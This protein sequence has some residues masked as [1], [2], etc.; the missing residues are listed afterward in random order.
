M[1]ELLPLK[2]GYYIWHYVPSLPAAIIFLALYLVVTLAQSWRLWRTRLWFC[3]PF[4][5]GGFME[6]IGYVFR[7]ICNNETNRLL[8]Y[9][10]QSIFILL[11]PILFAASIYMVLGRIIRATGG[12]QYSVI[13]PAILTKTFV[14]ADVVA[15]CVQ[16]GGAG[17]QVVS[18]L[19]SMGEWIVVAGLVIQIAMF[20]FFVVTAVIF[21]RRFQHGSP[22]AATDSTAGWK[23]SLY[24]LY[25]VS[26]LIMVRSIF[27][28]VEFVTGYSGYVMA[29]EWTIYV[30]D[31]VP[32][33]FVM[34]IF[35][36]YWPRNLGPTPDD[37][38]CAFDAGFSATDNS[39]V[40]TSSNIEL[41]E[42]H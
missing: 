29:N 17:L 23:S 2:S 26:A 11:P 36:F 28:V 25:G 5:V 35:F 39:F 38:A 12:E 13:R 21:Q 37:Q 18:S 3:I 20:G 27:R 19:S 16:G 15:F 33:F 30:F 31:A 22:Q 9:I 40:K 41:N 32:M 7:A 4:V 14:W 6:V 42:R 8:P 24:M 10:V 1:G 34:V